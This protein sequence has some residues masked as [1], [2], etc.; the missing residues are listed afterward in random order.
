MSQTF[1][2]IPEATRIRRLEPPAGKVRMVLD[3]DTYNEVDDQ[4]ALAY[5]LLSPDRLAVEAIYAAPFHNRRSTGAEDGMAR[6]YEEILRLLGRL[7]VSPSGLVHRGARQFLSQEAAPAANPAVEDLIARALATPADEPLYVVAIG[8]LTNIATAILLEPAI[9]E[10]IVV[11]WLG[12]HALHWL[13]TREFNLM[14][15]VPAARTVFD[16]GAPLVHVPC[17]GVTTHLSTTGGGTGA[18][19]GGEER[20]W[21]LLGRHRQGLH[22]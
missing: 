10:H 19:R 20:H 18:L 7:G 22:R 1:P 13:H 3:T 2:Q 16:C 14:G 21:G 9:I 15:D 6:S 11:V 8:A 17:A 5:A 4:F 12:G